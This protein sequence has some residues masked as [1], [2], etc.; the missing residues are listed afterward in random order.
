MQRPLPRGHGYRHHV[1]QGQALEERLDAV[2]PGRF[3]GEHPQPE[4]ELRVRA[5]DAR[6]VHQVVTARSRR[7]L[8]S[9]KSSWASGAPRVPR[10]QCS[11]S[12]LRT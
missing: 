9:S 3:P 4:V 2:V 5:L 1:M 6:R 12:A 8:S 7:S 10:C 11:R